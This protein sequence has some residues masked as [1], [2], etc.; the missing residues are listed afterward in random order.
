MVQRSVINIFQLQDSFNKQK[1][2]RILLF[3]V[4]AERTF[5]SMP[6]VFLRERVT[7][8]ALFV[9]FMFQCSIG[10]TDTCVLVVL[11]MRSVD[12]LLLEKCCVLTTPLD[13][14]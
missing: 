1:F 6:F 13:C 10:Y 9:V 8:V 7:S 2:E 4:I 3:R 12:H 11:G 14:E 5:A